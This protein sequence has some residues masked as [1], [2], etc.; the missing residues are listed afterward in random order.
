MN[1]ING[2]DN[3]SLEDTLNTINDNV[4]YKSIVNDIQEAIRG[5]KTLIRRQTAILSSEKDAII[6]LIDTL[7]GQVR[8]TLEELTKVRNETVIQLNELRK[9]KNELERRIRTELFSVFQTMKIN[10]S[11]NTV[12][13]S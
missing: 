3:V 12:S 5:N 8:D 13:Q 6:E 7:S 11:K 1:I 4:D 10:T 2:I 9:Q